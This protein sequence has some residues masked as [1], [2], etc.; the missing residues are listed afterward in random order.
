MYGGY[1]Y[2]NNW[3]VKGI[4]KTKFL[5]MHYRRHD[6]TGKLLKISM[7][8][9]QLELDFQKPFYLYSHK[10]CSEYVTS[11]W[12][13]DTWNY[14]QTC[15]ASIIKNSPWTINLPRENDFFLNQIVYESNINQEHNEFILD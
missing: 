2:Y 9:T 10:E 15:N 8:W 1:G 3:L 12:I 7:K 6:T 5:I 4:E 11:T 13:T 14:L